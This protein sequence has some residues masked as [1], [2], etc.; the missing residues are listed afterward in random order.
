MQCH[1]ILYLYP[2]AINYNCL[3]IVLPWQPPEA[4][5]RFQCV[6]ANALM[7]MRREYCVTNAEA[8]AQSLLAVFDRS[9]KR[10]NSPYA[11][12]NFSS[13]DYFAEFRLQNI[14]RQPL[15][16]LQ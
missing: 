15:D 10:V 2:F 4:R 8:V 13:A 9:S 12:N 6:I 11:Q 1:S 16:N 14:T 3:R 7:C 5:G